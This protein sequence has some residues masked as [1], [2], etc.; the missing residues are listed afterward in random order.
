MKQEPLVSVLMNCYNGEKYLRE[1]IDSVFAQTY[2]NWE[3]IFWDN[4]STDRSAEIFKGYNDSRVKYYYAPTHTL[5][6]EAR[7][8]TLENARGDFFAFLDVDDWWRPEKLRRQ[9]P[10]FDDPEVG[11]ICSNY[12]VVQEKQRTRKLF[13][14]KAISTGWVLNDLLLHYPVGLLTLV[15]RRTAF[16]SL[17]GGFDPR[18]HIIGDC[19]MA[20]RLAMKWKMACCQ[21]PLA[22]YRLHGENA[23]QQQKARHV[24]E[25][26][27]FVKELGEKPETL[28]LSGYRKI[29]A[30]L[31]YM[32]GRLCIAQ[33]RRGE[34]RHRL[35]CLPWGRY[36]VKL[37]VSLI[38]PETILRWFY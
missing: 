9:M 16:E 33:G 12:W 21:E 24:A 37:G 25:Y 34:A 14:E 26:Q 19:D 22:Y 36:K 31:I 13:R 10:L 4:Q 30:E 20:V 8:Y 15:L 18:F 1:A 7:N 38:V 17:Q 23:G 32:Q 2:Q 6:Y 27:M 5:L 29:C 11:F 35:S 3:V 28:N